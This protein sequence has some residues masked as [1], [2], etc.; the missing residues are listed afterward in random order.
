MAKISQITD[1]I[2]SDSIKQ[3]EHIF[4]K[5]FMIKVIEDCQISSCNA[6][7]T[8]ETKQKGKKRTV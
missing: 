4:P 8:N 5:P 1:S 3:L 2:H 7:Q 6:T